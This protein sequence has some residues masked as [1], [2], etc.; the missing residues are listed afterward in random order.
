MFRETNFKSAPLAQCY[1]N[2]GLSEKELCLRKDPLSCPLSKETVYTWTSHCQVCVFFI[3]RVVAAWEG[4]R[5]G[6]TATLTPRVCGSGG[7]AFHVSAPQ[8]GVCP[9]TGSRVFS[10]ERGE[11]REPVYS[12]W[13]ANPGYSSPGSPLAAWRATSARLS[14]ALWQPETERIQGQ[15]PPVRRV[16]PQAADRLPDVKK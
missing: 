3:L 14:C 4:T 8:A 16:G 7:R 5:H 15:H 13:S 12:A 2:I 11:A 10:E 1:V 6:W 9:V